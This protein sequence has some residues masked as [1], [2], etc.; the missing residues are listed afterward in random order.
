M[1]CKFFIEIKTIKSDISE[2]IDDSLDSEDSEDSEEEK[3]S[4]IYYF[5]LK[6]MI[7]LTNNN[8]KFIFTKL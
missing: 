7:N 2:S 1:L 5:N 3:R 6:N 4:I 8:W